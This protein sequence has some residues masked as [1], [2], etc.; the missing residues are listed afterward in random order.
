MGRGLVANSPTQLEFTEGDAPKVLFH[1]LFVHFR[2]R[3][4]VLKIVKKQLRLP[5]C[6]ILI[7]TIPLLVHQT[8]NF[9]RF[10]GMLRIRLNG[11]P[12]S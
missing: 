7:L 1:L 4:A 5:C 2:N 11:S 6:F 3:I 9:I 8:F 10:K 12:L